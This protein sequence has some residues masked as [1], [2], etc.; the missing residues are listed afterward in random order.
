MEHQTIEHPVVGEQPV[1][2]ED[3][4]QQFHQRAAVL[5]VVKGMV[6]ESCFLDIERAM[7]DSYNRDFKIVDLPIGDAQDQGHCFGNIYVHQ[8]T[9]GG[10]AGDDYAGTICIPLPNGKFLQF[11]YWM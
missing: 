11:N 4:H 8:T 10:F 6:T 9:T 1:V 2:D 5:A 7:A 3:S